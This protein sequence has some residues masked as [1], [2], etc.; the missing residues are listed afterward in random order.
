VVHP[1]DVVG[2]I[3]A[4]FEHGRTGQRYILGGENVT[5]RAQAER[6][7]RLLGADR[8]F[9]PVP[10]PLTWAAAKILEPLARRRN[11]SPRVAHMVHYCA[12]RLQFYDSTK[13]RAALGYR[14]RDFT[15]ML[16]E[17]KRSLEAGPSR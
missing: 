5:F 13:A 6:A 17:A 9:V 7:A 4:A 10:P 8:R 2:G 15:A 11:R 1:D 16:E 12:N 14:A 3:V